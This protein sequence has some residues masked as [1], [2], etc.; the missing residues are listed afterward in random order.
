V[1]G[2]HHREPLAGVWNADPFG[3]HDQRWHDGTRWTEKVRSGPISGIDPPVIDPT[4]TAVAA[5]TPVS[6]IAVSPPVRLR[7]PYVPTALVVGV[8]LLGCSIA[9]V[10]VAIMV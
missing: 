1:T 4:P 6:P 5:N 10:V 9:L 3:R 7:S 2:E 8:A